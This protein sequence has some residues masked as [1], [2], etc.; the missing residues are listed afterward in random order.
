M[1]I[2]F[3]FLHVTEKKYVQSD[4]STMASPLESVIQDIFIIYL[5]KLYY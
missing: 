5:E 4:E 3:S 2:T 1:Y